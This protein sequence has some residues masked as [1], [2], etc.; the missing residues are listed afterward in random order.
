MQKIKKIEK[1]IDPPPYHWVG[2]GFKVHTFFPSNEIDKSRM[3]PFYLLDYNAKTEFSPS[4]NPRGVGSHP[5]R[6]FET[7]TID[8]H[9]KV[10]HRDSAGNS[11]VIH[12]GD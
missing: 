2:D 9:G 3:S 8:Y 12:E 7:V 6:G 11:G 10:A 1:I 5:H 4:N